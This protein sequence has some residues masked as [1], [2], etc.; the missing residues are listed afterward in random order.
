M[1]VTLAAVRDQLGI[2]AT[3]TDEDAMLERMIAAEQSRVESLMGGRVLEAT[4]FVLPVSGNG[5]DTLALGQG[6]VQT[7]TDLKVLASTS[8]LTYDTVPATDYRVLG[9][10]SDRRNAPAVIVSTSGARWSE[11]SSNYLATF[12]GGWPF[13]SPGGAEPEPW[14]GPAAFVQLVTDLVV[15]RRNRRRDVGLK[16]RD[17]GVP[18][19]I[20]FET[21]AEMLTYVRQIIAPY[22]DPMAMP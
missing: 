14:L 12:K 17:L 18:S 6:P 5:T 19:A 13:T 4:D 21:D 8:P 1:I 10:A 2:P 15:W 22:C 20:A 11:G 16:T 9:M 7:F 3:K